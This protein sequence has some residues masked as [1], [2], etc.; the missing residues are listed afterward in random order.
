M[1][2][3]YVNAYV[4]KIY[5]KRHHE[6]HC[7]TKGKSRT[8]YVKRNEREHEP[9]VP[10][11]VSPLDVEAR[12]EELV[13]RR[14]RA[15]VASSGCVRVGDV[16]TRVG[17]ERVEEAR[18]RLPCRGVDLYQL[19]VGTT[20][21]RSADGLSEETFDKVGVRREAVHPSPPSKFAEGLEHTVAIE[22]RTY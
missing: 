22:S 16:A 14:E 10:P 20:N 3:R 18:A 8:T 7:H 21:R 1:R 17:D 13:G 12:R 15:V 6:H 9:K 5:K 2:K 19:D 4:A 11:P